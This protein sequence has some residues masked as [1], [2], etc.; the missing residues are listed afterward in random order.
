MFGI[1]KLSSTLSRCNE[2]L[3][4]L[5]K[6]LKTMSQFLDK[7]RADIAAI[8]EKTY[9]TK[10]EVDL[11]VVEAVKPLI[12]KQ[13]ADDARDEAQAVILADLQTALS[14]LTGALAANDTDAATA[15]ANTASNLVANLGTP[16][17]SEGT[18]ATASGGEVADAGP[19]GTGDGT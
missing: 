19:V 13:A 9:P 8:A 6:E 11:A 4:H 18:D 2:T 1:K 3:I 17:S 12:E 5:T 10:E 16:V 7:I 14:E 15:A